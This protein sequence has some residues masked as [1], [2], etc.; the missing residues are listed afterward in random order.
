MITAYIFIRSSQYYTDYAYEPV[1]SV[2]RRRVLLSC[3][4]GK[5]AALLVPC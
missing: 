1:R 5:E 4:D 3:V 2:P